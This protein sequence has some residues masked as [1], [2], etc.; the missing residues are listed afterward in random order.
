MNIGSTAFETWN[1]LL[2]LMIL[3]TM[4]YSYWPYSTI[5]HWQT[6]NPFNFWTLFHQKQEQNIFTPKLLTVL[7]LLILLT[8]TRNRNQKPPQPYKIYSNTLFRTKYLL[9]CQYNNRH[10]SISLPR[11]SSTNSE[12]Q[13]GWLTFVPLSNAG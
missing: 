11:T 10:P 3:N 1:L 2:L 4:I 7:I 8:S 5:T 12:V 9:N 6:T 13:L